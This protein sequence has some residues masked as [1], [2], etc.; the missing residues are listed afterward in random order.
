MKAGQVVKDDEGNHFIIR[1]ISV[2][3]DTASCES[4]ATREMFS[5]PLEELQPSDREAF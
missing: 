3:R 2:K 4:V 5:I 1:K